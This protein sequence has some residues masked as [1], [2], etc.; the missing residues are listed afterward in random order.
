VVD[1]YRRN[2]EYEFTNGFNLK[3]I[4]ALAAGV[5][6]ALIGLF[7]PLFGFYMITRGLSV[8]LFR[9]FPIF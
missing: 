7:I 8:L 4:Y 3:A 1:L 5:L 6:V 9:L 2:G